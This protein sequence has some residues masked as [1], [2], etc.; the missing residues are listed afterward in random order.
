MDIYARMFD[1][2]KRGEADNSTIGII[3][4]DSKDETVLKYS[5]IKES[6]QL[7]TYKYQG[8]LPTEKKLIAKIERQKRL[9]G[10]L[11]NPPDVST[12]KDTTQHD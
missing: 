1:D 6:P 5:V 11:Q 4:C 2:L 7:F 12:E 9:I 3:L 8:V 10:A